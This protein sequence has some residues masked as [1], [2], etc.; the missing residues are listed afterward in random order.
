M[1]YKTK[2]KRTT[3]DDFDKLIKDNQDYAKLRKQLD[4]KFN[5]DEISNEKYEKECNKIKY[6][7]ARI[8]IHD[9]KDAETFNKS[10]QSYMT[11]HNVDN[12][13]LQYAY[14]GHMNGEFSNLN[15][16]HAH[17]ENASNAVFSDCNMD[18]VNIVGDM[19]GSKFK[20]C[21][22]S[23]V[24]FVP[25]LSSD[26]EWIP[27]DIADVSFE[28][29]N[30]EHLCGGFRTNF[31]ACDFTDCNLK[32]AT[33]LTL[34]KDM[35]DNAKLKGVKFKRCDV[36]DASFSN[37]NMTDVIFA[38]CKASQ[39]HLNADLQPV[40]YKGVQIVNSKMDAIF[41]DSIDGDM[42]IN[43][44]NGYKSAVTNCCFQSSK[45][46]DCRL[47]LRMRLSAVALSHF[48]SRD[49]DVVPSKLSN[50]VFESCTFL[51][52]DEPI[53]FNLSD[54]GG[55][56]C[57]PIFSDCAFFNQKDEKINYV[58][59]FKNDSFDTKVKAQSKSNQN[60]F[61]NTTSKQAILNAMNANSKLGYGSNGNKTYDDNLGSTKADRVQWQSFT[62]K[63]DFST[64]LAYQKEEQM[65]QSEN[66][67][68][69]NFC[70]KSYEDKSYTTKTK[71]DDNT[72]DID[73]E[74]VVITD[75]SHKT[76]KDVVSNIKNT[77]SNI[78]V[79]TSMKCNMNKNQDAQSI[80]EQRVAD[81]QARV[82]GLISVQSENEFQK[83]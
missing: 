68:H 11:R 23:N 32:D 81:S 65:Q 79:S 71:D 45:N 33:F 43:N 36:S 82:S 22:M 1:W 8:V 13:P 80:Y 54:N 75:V 31:K 62:R 49:K 83:Y 3:D 74:D 5:N 24:Q 76:F 57:K 4:D 73:D 61:T 25:Q 7:Q 44:T 51:Q 70:F 38:S 28:G 56:K 69:Q 66:A 48:A 6:L 42:F 59:Y 46:C 29:C 12:V 47:D 77:F 50:A 34:K 67:K 27:Q 18:S 26:N 64:V 9:N 17:I 52:D 37:S 2:G 39:L 16:D 53:Y 14:C 15:L 10:L 20:S 19:Y 58:P 60:G 21:S 30:L 72:I 63:I 41:C 78:N 40:K 35:S 55:H